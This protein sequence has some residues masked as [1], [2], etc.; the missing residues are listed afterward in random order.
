M[1]DDTIVALA[2]P[3]GI[4]ALAVVRL[5]GED[6]VAITDRVWRSKVPLRAAPDRTAALGDV[7]SK[8]GRALD[9]VVALVMRGPASATG[10]DVVEMTC[11]G[12]LVAPRLV[13]RRLVEEGARPAEPGEFT[14]RAFLNHKIDLAQAEAVEEVV[15]GKQRES[16]PS[17]G[18]AARGRPVARGSG[19][20]RTR[21]SSNWRAIEANIDFVDDEVDPVDG[22][23][24][25]K[26]LEAAAADVKGLLGAHDG[27]R[28][29][30]EGLKMVIVGRPN[31]GKSSLFN[32][33]L[34]RDRVI[35]SEIPGTT[36]DVVDG[37]V[38]VDGVVLRVHDTAGVKL[39]TDGL[40]EE[41]VRRTRLAIAEADLA[42]VMVDARDPLNEEDLG[43]LEEVAGTTSIV[44][45]NKMD[46]VPGA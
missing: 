46:L 16:P 29:L 18:A 34:G 32:R 41:A 17:G 7:T 4:G 42:V 5:S 11:H 39:P 22:P 37:L 31:V 1:E 35:V 19:S 28:Y 25:A 21:W 2:T 27:G 24:L 3:Q 6:A 14:R 15:Q 9:Q 43:I 10:E 30:R 40:E 13:L 20:S 8:D 44:V 12:G 33:L 26:A 23:E 38:G 45:A 36:R